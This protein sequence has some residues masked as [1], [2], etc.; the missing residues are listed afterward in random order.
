MQPDWKSAEIIV[1][2]LSIFFLIIFLTVSGIPIIGYLVQ[3]GA[4]FSI[5]YMTFGG[6]IFFPIFGSIGALILA[7]ISFGFNPILIGLW[8]QIIVPGAILG[9]LMAVGK[10]PAR[11]FLTAILFLIIISSTIF[12]LEKDLIYSVKR[13]RQSAACGKYDKNVRFFKKTYTIPA[14][15]FGR[16]AAFLRLDR[17][18]IRLEDSRPISTGISKFCLLEN[19]V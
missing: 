8:A 7:M 18:F 17:A 6:M 13:C 4:Y 2:Y 16:G 19:A 9:R 11:A 1:N 15:S 12:W 5:I 14:D 10:S 3:V